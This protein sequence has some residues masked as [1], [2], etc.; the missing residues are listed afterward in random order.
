MSLDPITAIQT[1]LGINRTATKL[2]IGG[3]VVM[4]AAIGIAQM[5]D[6]DTLTF[7]QLLIGL[8]GLIV[9]MMALTQL[10]IVARRVIAWVLTVC[11]SFVAITATG[12]AITFN[13]CP[14]LAS[15]TC[16][17]SF[18]MASSCAVSRPRA[19]ETA[20]APGTT[21]GAALGVE[22]GSVFA[23]G[24][25]L[26]DIQFTQSGGERVFIQFA[27]YGRDRIVELATALVAAG[28]RV[29]AAD[30]GGERIAAAEG[31]NEIRYF[32]TADAEQAAALASAASA[33]APARGFTIVDLSA[34]AYAQPTP[35]LLEIWV[36]E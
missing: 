27:G 25:T 14:R 1:S 17:L 21:P 15:A 28:W 24:L 31:M 34:S 3:F 32:N 5:S 2:T 11:F 23:A 7:W 16:I 30:R 19:A 35:G 9:I 13:A 8:L 4:A 12:Q 33:W 6:D 26:T 20:A 22:P 10:P 36:S 29:E 18:H